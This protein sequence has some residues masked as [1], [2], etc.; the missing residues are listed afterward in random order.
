LEV[1]RSELALSLDAARDGFESRK[2]K[3]EYERDGA[4]LRL[5]E[6]KADFDR[7][8]SRSRERDAALESAQ[9][10][11][12]RNGEIVQALTLAQRR[13]AEMLASLQL[14]CIRL[15]YDLASRVG[16]AEANASRATLAASRLRD[17]RALLIE[18]LALREKRIAV[19]ERTLREVAHEMIRTAEA[20]RDRYL[21]LQG[22]LLASKFMAVREAIRTLLARPRALRA[23]L[24]GGV[25]RAPSKRRAA[26][27]RKK[28]P[29]H[30]R[31]A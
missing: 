4:V 22:G 3:L 31:S 5:A 10:R 29:R 24:L 2:A 11:L 9:E 20:E 26:L 12:A 18:T 17:E 6:I 28:R 30:L 25:G 21:A 15:E 27:G 14:E 13:A 1:E 8:R 23:R 16:A 7:L 19:L